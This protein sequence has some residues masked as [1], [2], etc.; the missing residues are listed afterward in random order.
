MN[1][2]TNERTYVRMN[3]R[4]KCVCFNFTR[5]SVSYVIG[6]CD[7]FGFVFTTL[8]WKLFFHVNLLFKNF[9]TIPDDGSIS[10]TAS[11]TTNTKI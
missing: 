2:R 11:K 8:K 7:Y 9:L 10:S 4:T 1:E 5:L 3:E 6:Q